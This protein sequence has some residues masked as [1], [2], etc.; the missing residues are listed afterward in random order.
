MN[1]PLWTIVSGAALIASSAAAQA[2]D[3]FDLPLFVERGDRLLVEYTLERDRNG[4]ANAASLSAEIVI[5]DVYDDGFVATWTTHSIESDGVVVSAASPQASEFLLGVPVEYL[6]DV[7][8]APV[9]ISDRDSLLETIFNSS[10]LDSNDQDSVEAITRFFGSLP[11]DALAKAFLKVPAYMS[12]CQGTSLAVGTRNE[13]AVEAP[14]PVGGEPADAVVSYELKAVDEPNGKAQIEYGMSLDPESA[15]RMTMAFIEQ[16]GGGNDS[17]QREID[18]WMI[19]RTESASCD[20]DIENGWVRAVTYK[21]ETKVAGQYNSQTY[22][23]NVDYRPS[24]TD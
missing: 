4:D 13:Y 15:K 22:V 14:S 21:A 3:V 19:E 7:D 11:D 20:V 23:V 8:G 6:A 5:G 18:D 10:V 12:I 24:S 1:R 2:Q 9:R 16:A 17:M